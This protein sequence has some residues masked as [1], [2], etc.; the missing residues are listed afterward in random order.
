MPLGRIIDLTLRVRSGENTPDV[1]VQLVP[2]PGVEMISGS[3]L[4]TGAMAAGQVLK[5]PIKVRVVANGAW[6][7]GASV[8]NRRPDATVQGSGAVLTVLAKSG[9][10]V[11]STDPHAALRLSLAQTADERRRLGVAPTPSKSPPASRRRS[12]S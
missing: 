5:L 8:T 3:S 9:V 6:T 4:W 2:S 10:A 7:L 12:P 1:V 11:L